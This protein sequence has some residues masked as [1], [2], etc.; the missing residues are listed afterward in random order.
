MCGLIQGMR[1]LRLMPGYCAW[2]DTLPGCQIQGFWENL[3]P[4]YNEKTLFAI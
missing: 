3:Q 1:I 4:D 2:N